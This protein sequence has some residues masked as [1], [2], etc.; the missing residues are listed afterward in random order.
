M[1]EQ[2]VKLPDFL[3]TDLYKNSLVELDNKATGSSNKTKKESVL[4]KTLDNI[5]VLGKNN[6][7]VIVVINNPDAA[8]LADEDL[9]FLANILK[10][11]G[12]NLSDIGIVNFA[13]QETKYLTLK[14]Q[15]EASKI[16]LFGVMASAI[17]LPFTVPHFQVQNFDNCTIL[18]SPPL[19]EM[20]EPTENSKELKK[21]LWLSLKRMFD[22]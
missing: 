1:N 17:Q 12:L 7:K 19:G 10:A 14:E 13:H 22:V 18:Q 8:F 5:K 3:I 21:K 2:N 9:A 20:N 4:S 16:L 6:K 15:L 11:C